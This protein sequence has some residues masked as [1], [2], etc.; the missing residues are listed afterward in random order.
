MRGIAGI[1]VLALV[2]AGCSSGD[3][4]T[5]DAASGSAL[6]EAVES[7]EA[8]ADDGADNDVES[9]LEEAVDELMEDVDA[10]EYQEL[11][12]DFP[13]VV[14]TATDPVYVNRGDL[15][16]QIVWTVVL[17]G[18]GS[19]D[20]QVDALV[21]AGWVVVDD[22]EDDEVRFVTYCNL[23]GTSLTVTVNQ[24]GSMVT[25]LGESDV[26]ATT[27]GVIEDATVDMPG[28]G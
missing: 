13:S 18:E 17:Q 6:A 9:D 3:G 21:G 14:P 16:G 2:L 24:P 10:A 27:L 11:P 26:E 20:A 8:A 12:D 15:G 25:G 23:E 28:C 5:D 1:A 19:G 7:E 4:T 22:Y